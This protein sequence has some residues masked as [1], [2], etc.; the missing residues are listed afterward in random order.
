M[1][2][3]YTNGLLVVTLPKAEKAKPKQIPVS[4]NA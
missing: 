4:L 3:D 2:A 1:R